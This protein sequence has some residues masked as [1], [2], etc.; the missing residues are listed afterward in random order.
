MSNEDIDLKS[1]T[2]DSV[3]SGGGRVFQIFILFFLKQNILNAERNYLNTPDTSGEKP[4]AKK[5]YTTALWQLFYECFPRMQEISIK[6]NVENRDY[7]YK[8]ETFKS[9]M[10]AEYYEQAHLFLTAYLS[11]DLRLTKIDTQT[12]YKDLNFIESNVIKGFG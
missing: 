12:N 10:S 8:P 2:P 1:V 3:A 7:E 11:L 9:L 5:R 6:R 4:R